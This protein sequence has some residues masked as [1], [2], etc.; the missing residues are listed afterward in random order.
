MEAEE[1]RLNIRDS[2]FYF[3]FFGT[4]GRDCPN[5]RTDNQFFT[6]KIPAQCFGDYVFWHVVGG[7]RGVGGYSRFFVRVFFF[8]DIPV[9]FGERVFNFGHGRFTPVLSIVHGFPAVK[10]CFCGARH[11]G[12]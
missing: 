9:D 10:R 6:G 3:L 8:E 11:T 4:V 12:I 7:Q 5:T 1:R 2:T